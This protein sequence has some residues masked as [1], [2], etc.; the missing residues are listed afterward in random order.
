MI[1]YNTSKCPLGA[2]GS[3]GRTQFLKYK[4]V[5]RESGVDGDR[6]VEHAAPNPPMGVVSGASGNLL[7][8]SWALL[9]STLK[10]FVGR[11]GLSCGLLGRTT[12]GVNEARPIL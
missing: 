2:I 10:P 4:D 3:L 5:S 11:P 1:I 7:G 9:G 6:S 12:P 8:P